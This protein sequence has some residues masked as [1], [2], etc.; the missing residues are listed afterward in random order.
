[1]IFVSNFKIYHPLLA[2]N[3]LHNLKKL[4]RFSSC[5]NNS[6]KIDFILKNTTD[7]NLNGI[8]NKMPLNKSIAID[9]P[10][11]GDSIICGN[12]VI[13]ISDDSGD[14][15]GPSNPKLGKKES[16][17]ISDNIQ[18]SSIIVD[19]GNLVY[20]HTRYTCTNSQNCNRSLPDS[21]TLQNVY[22]LRDDIEATRVKRHFSTGDI[23]QKKG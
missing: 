21:S 6:V 19:G 9:V 7:N 16:T 3:I 15:S 23:H 11:S 1:M 13:V 8:N 4:T 5:P 14:E 22:L 18:K 10:S 17:K 2:R 12:P 20:R